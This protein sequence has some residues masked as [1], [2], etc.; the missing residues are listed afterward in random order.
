MEFKFNR[1]D[2]LIK[3][4][5]YFNYIVRY[6]HNYLHKTLNIIIVYIMLKNLILLLN[7]NYKSLRLIKTGIKAVFII[8]LQGAST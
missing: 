6:F 7:T 3:L 1:Q 8:I 4:G 2:K 5:G